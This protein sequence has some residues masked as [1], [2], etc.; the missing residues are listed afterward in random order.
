MSSS[1]PAIK[2]ATCSIGDHGRCPGAFDTSNTE[3]SWTCGCSCH[4]EQ[5]DDVRSEPVPTFGPNWGKID[6]RDPFECQ[7][8]TRLKADVLR[9]QEERDHAIAE[10]VIQKRDA[11]A[12][13]V[14][15]A[16]ASHECVALLKTIDELEA[17]LT[18]NGL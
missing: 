5:P 15:F 2:S 6:G 17:A 10:A 16:R 1:Q 9:L 7:D 14:Q 4:R 11:S 3:G 8:C 12:N 18:W 13:L